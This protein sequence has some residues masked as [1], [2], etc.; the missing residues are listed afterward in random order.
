MENR[1]FFDTHIRSKL[2]VAKILLET[3]TKVEIY[4]SRIGIDSSKLEFIVL[5]IED[6]SVTAKD[7]I[8]AARNLYQTAKNLEVAID[9]DFDIV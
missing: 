4:T 8:L 2:S 1:T 7:L 5:E 9:I 3:D 6:R